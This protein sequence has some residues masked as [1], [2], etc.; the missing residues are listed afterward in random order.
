MRLRINTTDVTFFCT[1]APEPRTDRESGAPRIDKESGLPLWQVQ[2][3]ALDETGGEVLA[4]SMAGE[5][6]VSVGS[7]ISLDGLVAIPWSQ[8]DRSGVAYRAARISVAS[9]SVPGTT[10]GASAGVK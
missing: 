3:A 8:G 4:V 6:K 10:T 7:A 1:R 9:G 2:L 5:P